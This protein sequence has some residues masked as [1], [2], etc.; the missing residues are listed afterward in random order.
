VTDKDLYINLFISNNASITIGKGKVDISQK[1]NFPWDGKVEITVSPEKSG[2][3]IM[4]LRIPG[5]AQNEALPGGL[6]K[7]TDQDTDPVKLKINGKESEIKVID[8]YAL[9]SRKWEKG[10]KVEI[11]F[12]MP[13][14]KVVADIRVKEDRDKI[15]F[16]RGPLIFCAEWPDNI[17][18]KVL[19]LIIKKN[20][21]F[22]TEFEPSLLEGTQ[23]IKTTGI[24]IKK[25]REGKVE[26]GLRPVST[27]VSS[28]VEEPVKLI[29][30]ALW[31]NRGAGQMMVW[32]PAIVP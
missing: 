12:P 13:V 8:G 31:N 22:T 16:Q 4:R 18:G 27:T 23:V 15:A 2:E 7:F 14:R 1:A 26:P 21:S 30:Y 25:T 5:W 6:Y 3:F 24:Y 19:D 20:A 10:D 17:N 29:P 32:F 28:F 9:V 11:D